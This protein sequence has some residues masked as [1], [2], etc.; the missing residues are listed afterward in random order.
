MTG[1]NKRT[2]ETWLEQVST[3]IESIVGLTADDMPDQPYARWYDQGIA[4]GK[5]ALLALH[6]TGYHGN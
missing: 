2:F 5:A 3:F 4:P 6:R 1:S